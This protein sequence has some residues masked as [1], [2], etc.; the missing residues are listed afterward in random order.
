MKLSSQN[1]DFQEVE[2][3]N[4]L[5]PTK[6]YM[7]IL[8]LSTF[9]LLA[10][11][12]LTGCPPTPETTIFKKWVNSI[13]D[14][15]GDGIKCYRT[16]DYNFPTLRGVRSSFE[17]NEDGTFVYTYSG[18]TDAAERETGTWRKVNDTRYTMTFD[19]PNPR[20]AK[21]FDVDVVSLESGVL[22]IKEPNLANPNPPKSMAELITKKWWNSYEDETDPNNEKCFRPSDFEFPRSRGRKGFEFKPNGE[23]FYNYPGP[24]DMPTTESGRWQR[25]NDNRI[26]V[27]FDKPRE[28]RVDEMII[29]I[30]SINDEILK[31]EPLKLRPTPGKK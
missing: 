28:G 23:F 20:F 13:E 21:T 1:V 15:R 9:S 6:F 3:L 18:P 27:K 2:I 4:M 10:L 31:I 12:F 30:I 29:N 17:F 25:L 22:K 19:D 16:S 7:R 8:L 11:I 5:L 24:T 14:E 26:K